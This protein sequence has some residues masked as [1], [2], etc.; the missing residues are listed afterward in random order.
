VLG[1]V[2]GLAGCEVDADF[3]VSRVCPRISL[4]TATPSPTFRWLFQIVDVP[5]AASKRMCQNKT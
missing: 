4:S 3:R 5:V 1:D 2:D